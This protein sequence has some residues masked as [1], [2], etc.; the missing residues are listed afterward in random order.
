M[1]KNICLENTINITW[2]KFLFGRIFK[3][4]VLLFCMVKKRKLGE[5]QKFEKELEEDVAGVEKWV[6]LRR[7]FF[8][9]L[10]IFLIL[11]IFVLLYSRFFI[12]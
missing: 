1:V 11:L 12:K 10:G 8:I 9:K 5:F 7:R 3:H 4:K 2:L 6:I